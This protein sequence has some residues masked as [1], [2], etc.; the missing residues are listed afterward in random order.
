L[1]KCFWACGLNS[2]KFVIYWSICRNT[3]IV[4]VFTY[5]NLAATSNTIVKSLFLI[6]RDPDLH[7]RT[8]KTQVGSRIIYTCQLRI[9][10][11]VYQRRVLCLGNIERGCIPFL[12]SYSIRIATPRE[13]FYLNI[14]ALRK[15]SEYHRMY[16]ILKMYSQVYSLCKK[17]LELKI[18]TF[19]INEHTY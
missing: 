19:C 17:W 10:R 9:R 13:T 18:Y 1:S 15:Y 4:K 6:E 5:K 12:R 16:V 11:A 14:Y 2:Q 8:I 7:L 3:P